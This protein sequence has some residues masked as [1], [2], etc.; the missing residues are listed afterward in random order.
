M[1]ISGVALCSILGR[2][3][4]PI[5]EG[6]PTVWRDLIVGQRADNNRLSGLPDRYVRTADGW[7]YYLFATG[8]E[9]L[10]DVEAD[11]DEN[12]DLSRSPGADALKAQFRERLNAWWI[13]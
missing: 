4:R 8:K 9:T 3:L 11:P 12:N 2:S 13:P 5:L 1:R 10:F 7:K 6:K